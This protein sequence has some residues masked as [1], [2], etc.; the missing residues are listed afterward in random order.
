MS[1]L[2]Q[3]LFGILNHAVDTEVGNWDMNA[4]D[5]EGDDYPPQWLRDA[6]ELVKQH[7]GSTFDSA[8]VIQCNDMVVCVVIGSEEDVAARM[9]VEREAYFQENKHVL[10]GNHC[11]GPFDEDGAREAAKSFLR[12]HIR[13]VPLH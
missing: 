11:C 12:F 7:G 5:G 13:T 1:N 10:H 9:E 4:A 6:D 8:H 3:D 2:V